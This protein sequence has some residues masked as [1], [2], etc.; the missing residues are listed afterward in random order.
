VVVAAS[1]SKKQK[2]CRACG[3]TVEVQGRQ[4]EGWAAAMSREHG[5]A[6]V[7]HGIAIFGTYAGGA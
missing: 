7:S 6:D 4:V 1:V 3:F 5:F 2:Q